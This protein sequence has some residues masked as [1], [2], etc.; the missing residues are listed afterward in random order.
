MARPAVVVAVLVVLL[1]LTA[2]GHESALDR[3]ARTRAAQARDVARRA[4]LPTN[5]QDV[6]ARYATVVAHRFTVTYALDNPAG[7]HLT[8]TQDP[9]DRRVDIQEPGDAPPGSRSLFVNDHGST[10]CTRDTIGWMCEASRAAGDPIGLLGGSDVQR[11]VDQL[12]QSRGGYR[13]S[14]IH[15]TVAGVS[16]SCLVTDPIAGR[17]PP[18]ARRGLLCLSAE[19]A[20]LVVE[21]VTTPLH[22]VRYT[23]HV[24]AGSFRPPATA[25]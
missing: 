1:S 20:P 9:P 4:G 6:L 11:T 7:A 10:D 15:R 21:G 17:A 19:G 3:T 25:R 2:C 14:V 13:F 16:A 8:L 23:T 24:A 12:K 5:V 22:A 18:G